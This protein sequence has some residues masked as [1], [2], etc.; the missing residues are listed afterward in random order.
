MVNKVGNPL[1]RGR[2]AVDAELKARRRRDLL[3]AALRL[4]ERQPYEAITMSAVAAA[5]GVAK[6]TTY[7]YFPTREA[8]FLA[9]LAE[10]YAVW[11]DA[12]DA[13]LV[14]GAA[15]PVAWAGWAA[16]T[17]AARPLFL[18][19]GGLLHV[20]LEANVPLDDALLFKRTLAA[21][22]E[23]S[24]AALERTL[25]LS[26]GQGARLLLWL[27][28]VVPSLAQM[29]APPPALRQALCE[30]AALAAFQLDFSTELRAL[31][32][33]WLQGLAPTKEIKR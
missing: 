12:L 6:G 8:L 28:A 20:V 29:A 1:G 18:R 7:L 5:A 10:H 4:F 3:A 23:R 16:E 25:K 27:Q 2:R 17:L 32:L 13:R 24:G 19:L 9:L 31:L 30:D 15:A 14:E 26:A 11:F 21:R 33:A 22:V